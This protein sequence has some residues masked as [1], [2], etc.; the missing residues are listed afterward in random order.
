M[1]G[2]HSDLPVPTGCS[3][4][5]IL[6]S[7]PQAVPIDQVATAPATKWLY[8]TT[9]GFTALVWGFQFTL[10]I[11]ATAPNF[12]YFHLV[13]SGLVLVNDG[14]QPFEHYTK[15]LAAAPR[16]GKL[17]GMPLTRAVLLLRRRI[18]RLLLSRRDRW[19]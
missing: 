19:D 7:P 15:I 10:F 9:R 18:C 17:E 1:M 5:L 12:A 4:C 16:L 6:L 2:A 11:D 13:T 14:E 8:A 3:L